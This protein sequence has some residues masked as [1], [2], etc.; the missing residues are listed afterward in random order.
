VLPVGEDVVV[1]NCKKV[2]GELLDINYENIYILNKA[3]LIKEAKVFGFAWWA[4]AQ[5]SIK[6]L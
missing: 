3:E 1:P 5:P 6:C 2:G 4:M